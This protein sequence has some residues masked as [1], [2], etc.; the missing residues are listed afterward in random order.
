MH[1]AMAQSGYPAHSKV[2][3]GDKKAR[4][5]EPMQT[6]IA[7]AVCVPKCTLNIVQMCVYI[8]I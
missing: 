2:V 1:L 7:S 6:H 3:S 8:V 4:V 5:T